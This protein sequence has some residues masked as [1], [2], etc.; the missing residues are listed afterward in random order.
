MNIFVLGPYIPQV[1][2]RES[3]L[4]KKKKTRISR[5]L[6]KYMTILRI[7]FKRIF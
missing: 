2:E 1:R 6:N 4:K 3:P 7:E 5:M